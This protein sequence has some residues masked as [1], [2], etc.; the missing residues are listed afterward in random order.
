MPN[1]PSESVEKVKVEATEANLTRISESNRTKL[2]ARQQIVLTEED[3]SVE[4]EGKTVVGQDNEDD[5]RLPSLAECLDGDSEIVFQGKNQQDQKQ[6]Q[7][8][9]QQQQHRLSSSSSSSSNSSSSLSS[10]SKGSSDR[11]V[12]FAVSE[13]TN[14]SSA[15]TVAVP[16]NQRVENLLS[17]SFSTSV[18]NVN[19]KEYITLGVLGKGGSS[20]VNRVLQVSTGQIYAYKRVE[21]RGGHHS[22][23]SID[24]DYGEDEEGD[25]VFESY[26]NEIKLLQSLRGSP[27]IIELIDHAASRETHCI[28]MIL[29]AGDVDLAKVLQQKQR[30][31]ASS[32]EDCGGKA[33]SAAAAGAAAGAAVSGSGGLNPYFCRMVWQEML[34]AVDH[35]HN[36]R[37]VHGNLT[38]F[39]LN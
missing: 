33:G 15:V 9:H 7:H 31:I 10:S 4:I 38:S 25:S 39:F 11:M 20:C 29:E 28:S 36:N 26:M 24:G 37:I 18:V 5:D 19:G 22:A 2:L 16:Q 3:E 32:S 23:A 8:Q 21:I 12:S 30:N 34:E 35:I 17:G 6:N 14:S 13:V 27:H 1:P